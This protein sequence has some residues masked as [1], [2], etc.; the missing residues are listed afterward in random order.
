MNNVSKDQILYTELV[1]TV[2]C[3]VKVKHDV[4]IKGIT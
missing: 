3:T 2:Q 1:L 4:A